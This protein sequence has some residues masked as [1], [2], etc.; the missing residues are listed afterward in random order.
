MNRTCLITGGSSGIGLELARQLGARGERLVV[1]GRDPQKLAAA[2]KVLGPACQTF[3][4]DVGQFGELQSVAAT[5][6][7]S[8]THIDF[9]VVN[10]GIV[11][12]ATVRDM[13]FAPLAAVLQ[14]NLVGAAATVKAFLPLLPAGSRILFIASGF[15][16][17]GAA[18]Y[19]AYC[20]SKAGLVAFAEALGR[21][22]QRDDI[23]VQV[24]CL[25]DIDTPQ[26]AHESRSKPAWMTSDGVRTAPMPVDRACRKILAQC[27]KRHFFIFISADVRAL[28]YLTRF[29]PRRFRDWLV[30]RLLPWPR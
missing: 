9:L 29:L 21:E 1:L 18:G 16:L 26:F 20:A 2:G 23:T 6:A 4:A 17:V 28:Y 10:A 24:A 27:D 19:A 5:L 3:S 22:L 13:Q 30:N 14:T 15:S 12:V 11:E 8:N 25:T 7:S